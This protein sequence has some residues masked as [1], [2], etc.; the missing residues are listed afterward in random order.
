MLNL[1]I[2]FVSIKK[3]Y[4]FI[5]TIFISG[6]S[7]FGNSDVE[8]APY[9]V[10]AKDS[11]QNIEIRHYEQLILISAPMKADMD[12][13]KNEPFSKLFDYIS[14]KNVSS[15]KIP[16][17]APVI[18]S[19]NEKS[20]G[21]KIPMTAP[22]FMETDDQRGSMSFVLPASY[23]LD[24]APKPKDPNV[25]VSEIKNINYAVIQFS[26]FLSTNNINQH[27]LLL[28]E[29]IKDENLEI[30]GHYKVAGYNPPFTIP[31]LRRNEVLIPVSLQ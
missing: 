11:E 1:I 29:W 27:R 16:M 10:L 4:L 19:D 25:K 7:V 26:G 3:A 22:V 21:V 20:D 23:T 14:G 17:T 12:S 15:T 9:Q 28:E 24:T 8:I 6:C 5:L 13:R 30:I 18:L 31:A 2:K